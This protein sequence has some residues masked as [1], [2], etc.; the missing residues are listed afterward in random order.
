MFAGASVLGSYR[1]GLERAGSLAAIIGVFGLLVIFAMR[2]APLPK[3]VRW[4]AAGLLLVGAA[5]LIAQRYLFLGA[6]F[7]VALGAVASAAVVAYILETHSREATAPVAVCA[8]IWL[9]WGTI[10]FGLLQGL[11]VAISAL[12][13]GAFLVCI[14]A[15]RGLASATVLVA[16]LFY[17]VFLEAFPTDSRAIEVSQHYA[18]MGIVAGCLFPTLVAAWTRRIC[19]R[20]DP[21]MRLL[22]AFITGSILVA[23]IVASDFILGSRGTV[24]MLI[25]LCVAPAISGMAETER[26]GPAAAVGSLGAAIVLIFGSV[27]PNLLIEREQ[28]IQILGWTITAAIVLIA[29]A[30]WLVREP[31][32]KSYNENAA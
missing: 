3:Y 24:G 16:L 27:A 25:G 32:D 26:I 23:V 6:S 13:A 8:F 19:Q 4:L 1:D 22:A 10:A 14:G 30:A 5:A 29:V 15:R 17:R 21:G 9:G 31:G 2:L 18:V 28:K 12:F 20:F 7:N 11:G